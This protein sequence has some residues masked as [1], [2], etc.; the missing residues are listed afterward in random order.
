MTSNEKLVEL[1]L[2]VK[3]LVEKLHEKAITLYIVQELTRPKDIVEGTASVLDNGDIDDVH[4]MDIRLN[5][6]SR[7]YNNFIRKI[8]QLNDDDIID[9]LVAEFYKR[10]SLTINV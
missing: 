6:S 8:S 3:E 2:E 9:R 1:D 5:I 7:H 10:V 4:G